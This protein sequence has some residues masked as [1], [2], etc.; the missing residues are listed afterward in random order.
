MSIP[1][2]IR[3]KAFPPMAPSYSYYDQAKFV[4]DLSQR[5]YKAIRDV[6]VGEMVKKV[7]GEEFQTNYMPLIS[8]LIDIVNGR[9]QPTGSDEYDILLWEEFVD[10]SVEE[11]ESLIGKS[12]ETVF[13][14]DMLQTFSNITHQ[15]SSFLR[16]RDS[17]ILML[18]SARSIGGIVEQ[19]LKTPLQNFKD[20]SI[21]IQD[22]FG[23][24][25]WLKQF[26]INPGISLI[27]D[28]GIQKLVNEKQLRIVGIALYDPLNPYEPEQLTEN[29]FEQ[30][31]GNPQGTDQ[32]GNIYKYN[33]FGPN[34]PLPNGD[35]INLLDEIAMEHDYAYDQYGYN[36][37]GAKEADRIMVMRIKEAIENGTINDDSKFD[38]LKLGKSAMSYFSYV[39]NK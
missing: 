20:H 35:P 28:V 32:F 15:D 12:I 22:R 8:L 4:T 30:I 21:T 13:T 27:G 6:C 9:P 33:Y 26:N 24:V 14:E 18:K 34:N 19:L 29:P 11:F 7:M 37:P 38:E 10:K 3:E 1:D 39:Q 31:V 17:I 16:N 2:E 5:G 25:D 36:T 23:M